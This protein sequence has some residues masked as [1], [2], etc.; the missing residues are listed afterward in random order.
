MLKLIFTVISFLASPAVLNAQNSDPVLLPLTTRDGLSSNTVFDMLQDANGFLWIATADG[1]NRFDGTEVVKYLHDSTPNSIPSNFVR[2]LQILPHNILAI[3]TTAGLCLFDL[4]N[5]TYQK[6]FYDRKNGM[7]L[8]DNFIQSITIDSNGNLWLCTPT[9]IL[10]INPKGKLIRFIPSAYTSFDIGRERFAFAHKIITLSKRQLLIFL[11]DGN[12]IYDIDKNKMENINNPEFSGISFLKN[13]DHSEVFEAGNNQL[14]FFNRNID[15]IFLFNKNDKTITAAYYPYERGWRQTVSRIDSNQF[16]ISNQ[17]YG[18]NIISTENHSIKV[19]N[20]QNANYQF[21]KSIKDIQGN[22]WFINY[23][24]GLLK[25]TN[26][27]GRFYFIPLYDKATGNI[28][29]VPVNSIMPLHNYYYLS[30]YGKGL[31]MYDTI[32]GRQKQIK[33]HGGLPE[34]DCNYVWPITIHSPDTLWIGTQ[35]GMFWLTKNSVYGRLPNKNGKPLIMDSVAISVQ[36]TDGKGRLWIGLGKGNGICLYDNKKNE[37]T[38][39]KGKLKNGYPLRYPM[40]IAEDS[41]GRLW[42]ASD[43]SNTLLY[44][45]EQSKTFI[46]VNLPF[47]RKNSIFFNSIFIDGQNIFWIGS[48]SGIVRYAPQDNTISIY[49]R[50]KGL[51]HSFVE[52]IT[53]DAHGN[54]W[55]NTDGGLAC[56]NKEKKLFTNFYQSDGLPSEFLDF[57]FHSFPDGRICTGGFGGPVIFD[58]VLLLNTSKKMVPLIITGCKINGRA[59]NLH[60]EKTLSLKSSEKDIS[61]QFSGVDLSSGPQ[62]NY[63]YRLSGG[64]DHQWISLGRQRQINFSNLSPGKYVLNLRCVDEA[65]NI[66][67]KEVEL[68]FRIK[69]PLTQTV[70]FYLSLLALAFLIFYAIYKYRINQ[71]KKLEIVRSTISRDLH[72]E[73][74]ANLTNISYQSLVGKMNSGD[75]EKVEESFSHIYEDSYKVSEAMREIIWNIN[76]ANDLLENALPKMLQ[77]ATELLEARQIKVEASL[78][79]QG[80]KLELPMEQRRDLY[81]I[82]KEAINNIAK[83]ANASRVKI[84]FSVK[85]QVLT[86]HIYDDGIGYNPNTSYAGNGLHNMRSR[87]SKHRWILE[88]ND[89]KVNGSS[90]YLRTQ[91]A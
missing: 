3:G 29:D 52:D 88:L 31:F 14:L 49:G 70:W 86:L 89:Q 73:I 42:F 60:K 5:N 83:H 71:L 2:C 28:I 40:D 6:Y 87:A 35:G 74:G 50:E 81:L 56:F 75:K 18:Y 13:K 26:S 54:L 82:F 45:D 79:V 43:Q 41:N 44:F 17:M 4:K 72:D 1:L 39:F 34:V 20:K 53:E 76:P 37:F 57:R 47:L 61:F 8:Y 19:S 33:F 55:I 85:Q 68:A 65:G 77:Y 84:I 22:I 10:N 38:Y 15:S 21:G 48:N 58:P 59:I 64:G 67:S 69:V 11:S 12:Y 62:N 16:I 27:S 51:C 23:L 66:I 30:S 9:A 46:P 7:E 36:Y 78:P 63:Q 80:H 25:K 90:F 32:T 24:G 91:L